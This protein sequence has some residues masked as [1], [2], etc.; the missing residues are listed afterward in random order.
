MEEKFKCVKKQKIVQSP[1]SQVSSLLLSQFHCLT[2]SQ[3]EI[4]EGKERQFYSDQICHTM[5]IE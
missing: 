1:L 3:Y 4:P 2:L 5:C